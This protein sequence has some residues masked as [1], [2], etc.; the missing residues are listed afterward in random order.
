MAAGKLL[1]PRRWYGGMISTDLEVIWEIP[2]EVAWGA[3]GSLLFCLRVPVFYYSLCC[4][5]GSQGTDEA[6]ID[7]G[8]ARGQ[9]TGRGCGK[10]NS[11]EKTPWLSN[12]MTLS[13]PGAAPLD[14]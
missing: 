12:A 1:F 9:D 13:L 6:L 2:A 10:L 11:K 7:F 5:E 3:R 14:R 8:Q 4:A